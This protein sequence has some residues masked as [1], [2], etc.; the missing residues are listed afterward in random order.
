[1]KPKLSVLLVFS[2]LISLYSCKKNDAGPI[3]PPT[4]AADIIAA[5]NNRLSAAI[6]NPN[7]HRLYFRN[8]HG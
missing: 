8:H 1:M 3:D 6:T 7:N 5:E 2:L 4:P